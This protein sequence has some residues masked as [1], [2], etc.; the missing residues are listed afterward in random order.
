MGRKKQGTPA[1]VR[2]NSIVCVKFGEVEINVQ[3]E[4]PQRAKKDA[5]ELFGILEAKYRENRQRIGPTQ[6]YV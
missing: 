3:S 2:P 4:D 1:G 5:M 6:S